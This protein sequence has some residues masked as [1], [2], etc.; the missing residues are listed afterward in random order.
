MPA[1]AARIATETESHEVV[2]VLLYRQGSF[3]MQLRDFNKDIPFPGHWGF[4][5]GS[6]SKNE[7]PELTARREIFEEIGFRPDILHKLGHDLVADLDG[8]STYAYFC[9]LT[10]PVEELV[11]GEGAD[12]VLVSPEDILRGRAYSPKFKAEFPT[13]TTNYI[14]YTLN[15]A[16]QLIKKIG[17]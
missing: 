3:L 5:S 10:K 9:E 8:L 12:M 7:P 15:K 4:F 2:A 6:I 11:L 14:P 1:R 13:A 17:L 16:M